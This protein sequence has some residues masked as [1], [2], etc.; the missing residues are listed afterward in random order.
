MKTLTTIIFV[1]IFA[2]TATTAAMAADITKIPAQ[3]LKAKDSVKVSGITVTDFT[4]GQ[5]TMGRTALI[6]NATEKMDTVV[7]RL[8]RAHTNGEVLNGATVA[9]MAHMPKNDQWNI[10]LREGDKVTVLTVTATEKGSKLMLRN[11]MKN[12]NNKLNF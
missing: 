10:T 1:A 11:P 5:D 3:F 4:P 7:T 2:F 9:G 8:L 12:D 6:M